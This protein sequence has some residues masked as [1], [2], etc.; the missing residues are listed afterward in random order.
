MYC[1]QSNATPSATKLNIEFLLLNAGIFSSN[2]TTATEST[3][4]CHASPLMSVV[5]NTSQK[6]M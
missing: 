2:I 4:Q 1:I 6:K 5:L 3:F